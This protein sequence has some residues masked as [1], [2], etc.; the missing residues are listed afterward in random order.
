[1][2]QSAERTS[3]RQASSS[4][5]SPTES[6]PRPLP[7]CAHEVPPPLL[8][9]FRDGAG[10]RDRRRIAPTWIDGLPKSVGVHRQLHARS[11]TLTCSRSA[12]PIVSISRRLS[13]LIP[14]ESARRVVRSLNDQRWTDDARPGFGTKSVRVPVADR[15][16]THE[17]GPEVATA[18]ACQR[19]GAH[20]GGPTLRRSSRSPLGEIG[21]YVRRG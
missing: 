7:P 8:F 5:G 4:P 19:I 16:L 2:P 12:R 20:D 21:R 9:L 13:A 3:R 1:M 18:P 15:L 11:R 14:D 17:A 6:T 10:R